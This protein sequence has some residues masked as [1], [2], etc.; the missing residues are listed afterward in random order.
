[1]NRSR[2]RDTV[3]I[4]F[5]VV[6]SQSAATSNIISPALTSRL[7]AIADDYE[8]YRFTELRFR[9]IPGASNTPAACF[10]PGITDTPPTTTATI[11][12][13][14]ESVMLGSTS[15][16]PTQWCVVPRALLAGMHTWYKTIPGTPA[17]AEELQGGIFLFAS[18]ATNLEIRGVCEFAAA[19]AA[20]NTPLDRALAVRRREKQRLM[21]LLSSTDTALSGKS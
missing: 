16:T 18:A 1:M 7:A 10:L 9:L 17:D 21:T 19:A 15:T 20:G 6:F 5:S 2:R 12:Q 4:P 13:C 8:E 3:S 14:I 11:M